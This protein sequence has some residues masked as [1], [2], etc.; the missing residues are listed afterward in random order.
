ML[1][2]VLLSI[3]RTPPIWTFC[4]TFRPGCTY[5][6]VSDCCVHTGKPSEKVLIAEAGP[7][8]WI[9]GLGYSC[10][11]M[12]LYSIISSLAI[13]CASLK[14]VC[15]RLVANHGYSRPAH[16]VKEH[17]GGV[18]IFP[19][20]KLRHSVTDRQVPWHLPGARIGG[21]FRL[22]LKAVGWAP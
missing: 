9:E 1:A 10:H 21:V 11:A 19:V 2:P 16:Y 13:D 15:D 3:L 8:A 14:G 22:R 20:S 18:S 6:S 12:R 17:S 7:G 4:W 5:A